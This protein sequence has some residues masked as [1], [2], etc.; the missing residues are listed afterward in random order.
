MIKLTDLKN[1]FKVIK[2]ITIDNAYN[3]YSNTRKGNRSNLLY[4]GYVTVKNGKVTHYPTGTITSDINELHEIVNTWADNAEYDVITYSPDCRASYVAEVR[5]HDFM[6][7]M[8]FEFER[9]IYS[10]TMNKIAGNKDKLKIDINVKDKDNNEYEV[11]AALLTD[12]YSWIDLS[13]NTYKEVMDNISSIVRAIA[14]TSL[15]NSFEVFN[16]TKNADMSLVNELVMTKFS[17]TSLSLK[18][19]PF[20]EYLINNLEEMLNKLKN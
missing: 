10:L 9:N 5:L 11:N 13:G 17:G 12:E 15:V 7:D 8:G 14:L 6:K 3:L 20:K 4:L 16:K 1:E 2:S 18:K 19:M